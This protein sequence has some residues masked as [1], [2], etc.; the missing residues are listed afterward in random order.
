MAEK[1]ALLAV[2]IR[3]DPG[4]LAPYC[5]KHTEAPRDSLSLL[6]T[7]LLLHLEYLKGFADNNGLLWTFLVL[8][9]Q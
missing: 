4:H 5:I 1:D 9:Y 2:V 7:C 3:T 8:F 6:K